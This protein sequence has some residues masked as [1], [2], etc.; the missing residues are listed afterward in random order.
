[1]NFTVTER[2]ESRRTQTGKG[3]SLELRYVVLGTPEAGDD[4]VDLDAAAL[5]AFTGA[6]GGTVVVD[7]ETL[8]RTGRHIEPVQVWAV[9]A[10]GEPAGTMIWDGS[11]TY[12]RFDRSPKEVGDSSFSFDTGGGTQHI[13]QSLSTIAKYPA[14]APD[15]KGAIGVTSDSVEGVDITVPVY[16]F[17]ETHYLSLAAV[18]DAYKQTLFGLTGK[19]NTAAFRGFAIGEVL[20]LGASGSQRGTEDWEITFRFAASKNRTGMVIGAI[21]GIDKKGWE[22]LWVSYKDSIDANVKVKVP[23]AVYIEQVYESGDFS[24]LGI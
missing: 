7:G 20:F 10:A 8:V 3:K 19:V 1:M 14:G 18:T 17:S 4:A 2:V 6:L 22:Y 16:N 21:T 11:A 9:D 15:C 13:T 12:E 5:A 23:A 24:G